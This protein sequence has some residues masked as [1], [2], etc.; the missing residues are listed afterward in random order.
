M[1]KGQTFSF[2]Q[3]RIDSG[4]DFSFGD[5]FWEKAPASASNCKAVLFNDVTTHQRLPV[6]A[7]AYHELDSLFRALY[8]EFV[9]VDYINKP[10]AM[11]A[12]LKIIMIKIANINARSEE[13]RVGKECRSRWSP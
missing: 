6:G 8:E 2:K 13:R 1:T 11:A 10:D 3:H 12:Y 7:P 5:Y 4:L 9:K